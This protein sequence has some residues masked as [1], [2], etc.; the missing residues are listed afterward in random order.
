MV[1]REMYTKFSVEPFQEERLL[2]RSTLGLKDNTEMDRKE[3][4]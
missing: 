1:E 2:G 4:L 3:N